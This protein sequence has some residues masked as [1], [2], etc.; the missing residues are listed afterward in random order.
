MY[1]LRNLLLLSFILLLSVTWSSYGLTVYQSIVS[2][3]T[4]SN[5][6]TTFTTL[7]NEVMILYL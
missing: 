6:V 5:N 4:S 3:V 2:E 1:S 7:D